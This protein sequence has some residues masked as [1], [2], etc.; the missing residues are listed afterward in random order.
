MDNGGVSNISVMV[1]RG[2]QMGFSFVQRK[3]RGGGTDGNDQ[4]RLPRI[5]LEYPLSPLRG[6]G[7]S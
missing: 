1:Y 3:K 6:D 2:T 7:I 5:A 4:L